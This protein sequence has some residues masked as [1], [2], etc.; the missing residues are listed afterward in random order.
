MTTYR[1]T[2]IVRCERCNQIFWTNHQTARYCSNK[3]RQ[4]AYRERKQA[5]V[6]AR[7]LQSA[8]PGF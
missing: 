6:E 5:Q 4:L 7:K 1:K 3:C 8:L 2:R